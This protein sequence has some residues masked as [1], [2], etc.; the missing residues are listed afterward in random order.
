MILILR[1]DKPEAEVGLYRI[2]STEVSYGRWS[3]HRELSATLLAKIRDQLAAQK[4]VFA[5]LKAIVVFRGPGSFT[6]IRIGITV[7]NA[8]A[9]GLNIPIIGETGDNWQADGIRRLAAHQNE[10]IV[11]P[12][13]GALAHITMPKT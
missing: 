2:D 13:Y 5:D 4:A 7:A 3:A 6:G 1:T 8:L 12:E 10:K 9:Y 11:L